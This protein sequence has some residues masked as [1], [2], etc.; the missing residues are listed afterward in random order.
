MDWIYLDNNATTMPAE[1]VT[2]AMLEMSQSG[3]ANPS[4]V[5][6]F[7][8]SVRQRLELARTQVA[9]L[10]GGRPAELIFTS[11]G[12]E[13]NNLAVLGLIN[14]AG[15]PSA[16]IT[17]QVEHSAVH[18]PVDFLDR[19]GCVV[20]KL[21]TDID[22]LVD[23]NQLEQAIKDVAGAEALP[24]NI[25][26][27]I[28]WAN[29]ETGTIQD[30]EGISDAIQRARDWTDRQQIRT[31]IVFHVDATQAV[32]KLLVD[33]QA[34]NLDMLT[35][36]SHKFHGPKGVGV[37]WLRTGIRLKAQQKGGPQERE[38][39][40]GTEN[41]I[42]IVG[43]GV[44]ADLA[45]AFVG[46]ADGIERL[47]GLRDHFER[48]VLE[49]LNDVSTEPLAVVNCVGAERLWNTTNIAFRGLEAEAILVGLSEKGVCASAG[50]ACSSGS[51]EASPVL[52][53]M[54]IA[55]PLAHGSVRFS[56]S[57][58]TTEAE[59]ED[60]IETVVAV[61]TRLQRTMPI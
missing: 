3:W 54:G 35:L 24:A 43:M 19:Q 60:A 11:G 56:L 46:D 1:P 34:M 32:G 6:R 44:A 55:E 25:L 53:A 39:R 14:P 12:T 37:L 41:T 48:S 38:R 18:G 9:R 59:I 26:I 7:G 49:K 36:A 58:Y 20:V 30:M 31:K 51:L 22:G 16:I 5:H 21:P 27:T 8:Q 42:G 4:S 10:I 57:R 52:R 29:N 33:V 47:R 45:R 2:Q 23:S 28:Q 50:A 17:T 15:A 13:A 40:A 61:V